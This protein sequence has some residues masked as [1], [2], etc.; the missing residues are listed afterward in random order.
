[1]ELL[2]SMLDPVPYINRAAD[3]FGR[4]FEFFEPNL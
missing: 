2:L 4:L 1:M 3:P